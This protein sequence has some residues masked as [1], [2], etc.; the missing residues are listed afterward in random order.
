MTLTP[1]EKEVITLLGRG[2]SPKE[3]A[4][5]LGKSQ[6]TVR[7]QIHNARARTGARSSIELAVIAARGETDTT[8]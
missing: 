5:K 3:I 1:A 7:N 2:L 4:H 6:A 8:R